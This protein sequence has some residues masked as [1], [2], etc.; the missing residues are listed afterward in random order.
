MRRE[1]STLG[2]LIQKAP[3]GIDVIQESNCCHCAVSTASAGFQLMM[4][5]ELKG[6]AVC[7]AQR[8]H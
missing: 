6:I 8:P 3:T 1:A 4:R 5:H 2:N 7:V